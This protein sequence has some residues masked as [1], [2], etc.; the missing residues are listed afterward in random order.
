MPQSWNDHPEAMERKGP[1]DE[2]LRLMKEMRDR[3]D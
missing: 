2:W 1:E 3:G